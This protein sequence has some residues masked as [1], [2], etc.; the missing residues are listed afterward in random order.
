MQKLV[1]IRT[2]ES[3]SRI[4]APPGRI[5][6]KNRPNLLARDTER[7]R[8]RVEQF[9]RF[10][11]VYWVQSVHAP[12]VR[13]FQLGYTCAGIMI[14]RINALPVEMSG[15]AD[16]PPEFAPGIQLPAPSVS[17]L[18]EPRC[19]WL[20]PNPYSCRRACTGS[21]R[22]A[23]RAGPSAAASPAPA[24]I[25]TSAPVGR[26]PAAGSAPGSRQLPSV[27]RSRACAAIPCRW[28]ARRF[29]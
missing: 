5:T 24:P 8:L 12:V 16:T 11:R 21:T 14:G 22:N 25:A 17:A 28:P 10:F 15:L 23:R 27:F 26:K 29:R 1:L 6:L 4:P 13:R 2:D 9:G 3:V 20:L 18:R 19:A 7:K